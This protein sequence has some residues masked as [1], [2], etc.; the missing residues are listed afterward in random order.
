MPSKALNAFWCYCG[1][2]ERLKEIEEAA[3]AEQCGKSK[4]LMKAEEAYRSKKFNPVLSSSIDLNTLREENLQLHERTRALARD[5]DR[6]SQELQKLRNETFLRPSGDVALDPELL[7]TLQAGPIHSHKLLDA[8]GIDQGDAE[9]V[10]AI[11]R[12]L[13]DLERTGF[14]ARGARGWRWLK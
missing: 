1:S 11:T 4:Y 3:K 13:E 5:N 9:A 7:Q 6:L 12:Q 10:R 8:L 14:I 2:A